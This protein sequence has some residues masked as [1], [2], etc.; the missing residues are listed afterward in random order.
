MLAPSAIHT[1]RSGFA[2]P[3]K[4]ELLGRL[5]PDARQ[6]AVELADDLGQGEL[7]GRPGEPVA[8]ALCPRAASDEP[9]VA[10][11][12]ENGVE[13]AKRDLLG[14]GDLLARPP[15]APRWR[16]ASSIIARTA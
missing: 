5:A 8:A 4:L 1:S 12:G 7:A 10:Q 13:E 16:P 11:L 2:S 9:R 15:G 14:A 3:R 6:G